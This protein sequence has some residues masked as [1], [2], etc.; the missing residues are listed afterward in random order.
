MS[1]HPHIFRQYDVRGV[2]GRDLT[3]GVVEA[4]GKGYG[5]YMAR[6][7]V[8][9]VSVGY[10]ARQSSPEFCEALT[11]GIV[12]TGVNVVQIGMVPTPILYFSFF[13][14]DIDGG[15]MITGSHNP[16]EFNGFKLG[17]GKTTI[18]GD[19][20]QEVLRIIQAGEFAQGQGRV[21]Q[22]DIGPAYMDEVVRRVGEI[23]RP[24]RVV[25]DA[26]NGAGGP[27]GPQMLRRIGAEVIE[28]YC[29]VD[30]RFPNHHPDPT[31][32]EAL[33]DLIARVKETGAD[34]GVA[35]DGDV[36]RIGV[37]DVNGRIIWGDQLMMLL[38][39]EV[40]ARHPGAPI[41]FEVK[42]SQGLVEEIERLGGE[43][44]MYKTGHSLIKNKMKELHAPL[45]GEMSGHL[46]F[47]DEYYGY[48]DA[49]YATCRFARLLA[50]QDRSLTDLVDELP[51]YFSTPETRVD[52]PEELKF[53][54]VAEVAAY[55]KAHYDHAAGPP[56]DVD[57]VRILFGDG[58]GLLRASNTQPVL[59]LRFEAKTPG[60]LEEIKGIVL[61]KLREIAPQVEVP[62]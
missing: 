38:S 39:R 21:T 42:C 34:L 50:A 45:A 62:L 5:T 32:P 13:H 57:G 20:I 27:F 46:F 11:G 16:P 3:P 58:W 49:L 22:Q 25:V 14:L 60:R 51:H 31:L 30:G 24:L 53:K 17:A 1:V 6:R 29:D 47:A 26:G 2:V 19:E 56:I 40:L 10:D 36:D 28:L 7:G 54:V 33:T 61:E 12:S 55:F 52:C 9:K 41:I 15:V 48:D 59:V 37:V 44:V 8:R 23:A 4:L 35:W 18:Y 43:P